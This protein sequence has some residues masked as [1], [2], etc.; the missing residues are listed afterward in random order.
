MNS[1]HMPQ[2]KKNI[3]KIIK[4]IQIYKNKISILFKKDKSY[5]LKLVK[6]FKIE[7][8]SFFFLSKRKLDNLF[9]F[10]TFFICF[11]FLTDD[12]YLLIFY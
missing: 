10:I 6:T 2:F 3:V 4:N 8:C 7:K 1:K 11:Q 12:I 5:T 9:I